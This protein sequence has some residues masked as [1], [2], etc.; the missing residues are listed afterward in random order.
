MNARSLLISGSKV[1]VL[2]RPPPTLR[3]VGVRYLRCASPR[4]SPGFPQYTADNGC[5]ETAEAAIFRS[6]CP[7]VSVGGIR[8]PVFGPLM[9]RSKQAPQAGKPRRRRWRSHSRGSPPLQ[10]SFPLATPGAPIHDNAWP[11][12]FKIK[13]VPRSRARVCGALRVQRHCSLLPFQR[14]RRGRLS[15]CRGNSRQ[16]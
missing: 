13:S 9:V 3:T 10:I 12:R 16:A 14:T 4:V 11:A 6:L 15:L 7:E 5:A 1:R 8:D 2:V